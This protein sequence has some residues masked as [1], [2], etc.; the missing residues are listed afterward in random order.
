[1]LRFPEHVVDD[2][3]APQG[4]RFFMGNSVTGRCILG[5]HEPAEGWGLDATTGGAQR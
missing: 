1:M 3:A 5:L 2:D 4:R